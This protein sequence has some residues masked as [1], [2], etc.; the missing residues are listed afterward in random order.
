MGQGENS[1]DF[2]ERKENGKKKGEEALE[3]SG[4]AKKMH[5]VGR[6]SGGK[7]KVQ[8]EE[9]RQGS[10]AERKV[11]EKGEE[12]KENCG[13]DKE[14]RPDQRILI[15]MKRLDIIKTRAGKCWRVKGRDEDSDTE[16]QFHN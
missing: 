8:L 14:E 12:V 11:K 13:K 7:G 6:K 3:E 9:R 5:K 1:G 4:R 2:E 15:D 10:G 16:T